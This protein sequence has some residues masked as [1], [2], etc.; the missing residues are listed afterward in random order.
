MARKF[1]YAIAVLVV[2]A[3]AAM[4][5]LRVWS[6]ELAAMALVPSGDFTAPRELTA[7]D[8]DEPTMWLS[9][10]DLAAG[11][12]PSRWLPRNLAGGRSSPGDPAAARYAV[13]FV[14]PTSYFERGHWNAPLGDPAAHASAA[15]FVQGLA[16][17]FNQRGELWAPRYRQ[18]TFGA[19]LTGKAEAQQALDVA[20][21]DVALAFEHFVANVDPEAP[22]VLAGHSQGSLL[23][24]RLLRERIAGTSLEQRIAVAY[25]V[26]WP[27]SLAHDLPS[28]PLPPCTTAG[29]TGCIVAWSSFAEPA[30]PAAMLRQF[31][32]SDGFDGVVR[33]KGPILCVNPVT[34]TMNGSAPAEANTGTLV[35][36]EDL[37]DGELVAG[38]VPARC[39]RNGLLLIGDAPRMGPYVLP[40]NN[41]HVYDIP[42][43]WQSLRDDLARRMSAWTAARS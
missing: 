9:R 5:A 13:F 39:D 27:I 40:G 3:I 42:L 36:D 33:G 17:A 38:A 35:P 31:S 16:S 14:H 15:L 25:P 6:E 26:G 23:L 28:L 19:F 24:L 43:F 11:R 4:F 22:I 41:Y 7:G 8:Y 29:Q 1:L 34:G 21:G 18:A 2:A 30:E 10:P 37:G 20:Y 32:A 12:D